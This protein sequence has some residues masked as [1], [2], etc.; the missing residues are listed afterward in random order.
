[1][2]KKWTIA[3]AI[4]AAMILV[5][6]GVNV[7]MPKTTEGNKTVSVT[8]I[9]VIEDEQIYQGEFNTDAETLGEFLDEAEELKA[10]ME[11]S[12][13]G[14]LLTSLLDLDQGAMETGPWW[15]YESDNNEACKAAGFCPAVDDT[16]I[17]DK[18][19]FTFKFTDSY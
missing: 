7:L 5:I 6:L 4:V 10:V 18:D 1:M 9:N 16:P 11:E 12:T 17:Q 2:K 8:V 15:L 19:H 14:R 13:Y 3:A